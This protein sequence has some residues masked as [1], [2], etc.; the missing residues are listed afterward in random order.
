MNPENKPVKQND[1][2][3]DFG[4]DM[5][6]EPRGQQRGQVINTDNEDGAGCQ[7]GESVDG[8]KVTAKDKKTEAKTTE[9][10]K[11][12]IERSPK[13]GVKLPFD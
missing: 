12:K 4:I 1:F 6:D 8:S 5:T 3:F 13:G 7:K 9:G 10:L 2:D 11:S